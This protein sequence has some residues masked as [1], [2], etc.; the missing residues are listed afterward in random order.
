M[1]WCHFHTGTWVC[2]P[3]KDTEAQ[4]GQALVQIAGW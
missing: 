2:F 4:G 1:R 3:D